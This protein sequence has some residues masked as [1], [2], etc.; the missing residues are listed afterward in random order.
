MDTKKLKDVLDE[1]KKWRIDP[2]KGKRADLSGANLRGA[3]L[4]GADLSGADLS[5]ADLSGAYLRGADLSGADLSGADLSGADFSDA[6]LRGA[7]LTGANIDF[8]CWP[9][10]CKSLHCT[11]DGKL[12]IQLLYHTLKICPK[13]D[14]LRSTDAW[15][16]FAAK[17]N[18]FH[19]VKECGE[20]S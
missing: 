10:S 11:I 17:A 1:H 3:D 12:F 8:S 14:G 16:I 6:D 7:N 19:R 20:L 13:D 5:G 2:L 15:K 18:K 9:L 4:R